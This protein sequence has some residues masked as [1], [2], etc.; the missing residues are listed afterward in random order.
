MAAPVYLDNNATT[1][2]DP[3]VVEAM[4]PWFAESYG[5]A[6]SPHHAFGKKAAEAVE[7]A[8]GQVAA[9]IGAKP[10][11]IVFT[12]G[13]TESDNLALK[14][15]LEARP[16]S[17]LVTAATEH[18]AV[19]EAARWLEKQGHPLTVLP[20]DRC[21]RVSPGQVEAALDDGTALVSL[22][23]ASNE[24]GTLHPLREI[25]A[26]CAR[27]GV[28]L[29]TDAAQMAGKLP[30]D[31]DALDVGL[32]SLSAHKMHGPKGVGA[33]YI[34]R[35]AVRLAAQMH[36]GGQERGFRSGTVPV[37]L[38]VGMGKAC[39]LCR[40]EMA[41]DA[42]RMSSL[43]DALAQ[44]ILD[45]LEAVT[46]NGHPTERLPGSLSLTFAGVNGQGLLMAL[47]GVATSSGSACTSADGQA[48]HVLRAIGLTEE[49]AHATLRFG[50]GR[51]TTAE[52]IERAAD[53]VVRTVR[54]LREDS[55]DW[56]MLRAGAART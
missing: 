37:P 55:P 11:E 47:R 14:G 43:R 26:A 8:R 29:H 6:S 21:G 25:G 45:R 33:L 18:K 42:A 28:P 22:M 44:A 9:L 51:F 1:R 7:I 53:E 52:E 24:I 15:V 5:N 10:R 19:L 12:S 41:E 20:V 23:A 54:R 40:D 34:R 36:G 27:R 2:C 4:L 31:V 46:S 3:R 16:G 13:A 35:P 38:A 56:I 32:M 30:L 17:R 50:L 39:E 49:A 48:S